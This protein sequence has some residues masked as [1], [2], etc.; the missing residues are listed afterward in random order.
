MCISAGAGARTAKSMVQ[1]SLPVPSSYDAKILPCTRSES[2]LA[3]R[4][5]RVFE[6]RRQTDRDSWYGE[7]DLN[8]K[9]LALAPRAWSTQLQTFGAEAKERR[10]ARSRRPDESGLGREVLSD[11]TPFGSTQKRR[12]R[13]E[14][15]FSSRGLSPLQNRG[16]RPTPSNR[17]LRL[18]RRQAKQ[19]TCAPCIAFSVYRVERTR[20]L[21]ADE[22]GVTAGQVITE[23]PVD[24]WLV[25]SIQCTRLLLLSRE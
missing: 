9:R 15:L 8:S 20:K 24:A 11:L 3:A 16:C 19:A 6:A 1:R 17:R 12:F 18:R 22:F 21:S 2:L 7:S 23:A 10:I 25:T 14:Q 4:A 13:D 5:L